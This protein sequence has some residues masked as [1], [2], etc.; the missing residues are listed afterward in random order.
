[1]KG[2]AVP[3]LLPPELFNRAQIERT[4]RNR[5][6]PPGELLGLLRSCYAK[7]GKVTASV[8][9]ADPMLPD[10]QLFKRAFGSLTAAYDQAGLPQTRQHTF[11]STKRSLLELQRNLFSKVCSLA[12]AAGATVEVLHTPHTLLLNGSVMTRVVVTPRRKPVRG[13]A[14]WAVKPKHGVHFT[15]AARY[16]S[17]IQEVLD[18]FLI[19]SEVFDGRPIYLKAVNSLVIAR[20]RY[21]QVEHMFASAAEATKIM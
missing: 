13:F 17:G 11:V 10:P 20:S 19:A 16:N 21:E 2:G 1:V 12:A 18:Y 8:I 3:L 5:R 7:N 15:I 9:A 6:Y 4:K 14:N